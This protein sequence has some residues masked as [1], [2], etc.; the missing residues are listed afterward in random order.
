MAKRRDIVLHPAHGAR[1]MRVLDVVLHLHRL[2]ERRLLRNARHMMRRVFV[3]PSRN[4]VTLMRHAVVFVWRSACHR[5]FGP[6]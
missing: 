5:L 4:C 6:V 3:K 1:H 2:R